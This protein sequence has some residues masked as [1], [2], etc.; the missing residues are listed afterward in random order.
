M[1]C[2]DP[3]L[4]AI[5]DGEWFCPD[6]EDDIGGEVVVGSGRKPPKKKS[7]A[8]YDDDP[9]AGQKRKASGKAGAAS[10]KHIEPAQLRLSVSQPNFC[11]SRYAAP[12]R[13]K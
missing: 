6:C 5:P 7:K 13:R 1:K 3:P 2:L 11:L 4:A 9:E 10:G 12:K 8:R